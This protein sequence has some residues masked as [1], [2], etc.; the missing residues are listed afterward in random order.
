VS[1]PFNR[2]Q[3]YERQTNKAAYGYEKRQYELEEARR[4][5]I[6]EELERD[7]FGVRE[8]DK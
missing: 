8:D 7:Y 4:E 6:R 2:Y 3:D 1:S 5:K